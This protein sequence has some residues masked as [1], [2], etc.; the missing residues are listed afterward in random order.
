MTYGTTVEDEHNAKRPFADHCTTPPRFR[1]I[2]RRTILVVVFL[3]G[4]IAG[5]AIA[6]LTG[7]LRLP[8]LE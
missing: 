6:V 1:L 4:Y 5:L 7:L 2:V 8:W 3:A